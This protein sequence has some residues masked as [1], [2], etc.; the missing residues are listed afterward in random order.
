MN[1][2][3]PSGPGPPIAQRYEI[4]DLLGRGGY[5]CVYKARDLQTG[6]IVALKWVKVFDAGVGIPVSFYR[7]TKVL[8]AVRHE[9]IVGLREVVMSENKD[10]FLVLE[11]C[12]F[13][14]HALIHE[15][16]LPFAYVQSYMKQLFSAVAEM[17]SRGY[18]HRDL[19]PANVFVT[20]WNV[21]KLGDFGLARKLDP[22]GDRP[23]TREVVTPSYRAPELLLGDSHYDQAVDVWALGCVL[24][25]SITGM[26]LFKATFNNLT[27]LNNIFMTCGTPTD[28]TWPG[29]KNMPGAELLA[30][31]V[32]HPYRLGELLDQCLPDDF[33]CCKDLIES[34]LQ[35]DP[36][37]RIRVSDALFHPFFENVCTNLPVLNLKES[38]YIDVVRAPV[39]VKIRPRI[40]VR[41]LRAVPAPICA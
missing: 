15:R 21:I 12:E 36:S 40:A 14:L 3:E 25:E 32:H 28:E 17:H 1:E 19:K 34:M 8:G 16:R 31:A 29:L 41:P 13:D 22:E 9:G 18:V 39:S 30:S 5:G 10:I 23:L 6:D 11:Y 24:F 27:Q 2:V 20:A 4:V 26:V 7:E 37:R 38:H 35:L 33:A